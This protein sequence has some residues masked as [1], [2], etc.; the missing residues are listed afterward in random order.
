MGVRGK[1]EETF[2]KVSSP[3]PRPPEAFIHVVFS[4]AAERRVAAV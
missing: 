2:P 3:F 4:F 1:G